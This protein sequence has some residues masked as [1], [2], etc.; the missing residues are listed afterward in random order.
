M[1]F[2]TNLQGSSY[3]NTAHF[4]TETFFL[5]Y[6]FFQQS[7]HVF[8]LLFILFFIFLLFTN[9]LSQLGRV[10][11]RDTLQACRKCNTFLDALKSI[12]LHPAPLL[13]PYHLN[14]T[15]PLKKHKYSLWLIDVVVGLCPKPYLPTDIQPTKTYKKQKNIGHCNMV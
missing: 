2:N 11:L 5:N 4:P 9:C 14:N 1:H 3:S 15:N 13:H 10:F 12:L 6:N 8:L 7:K